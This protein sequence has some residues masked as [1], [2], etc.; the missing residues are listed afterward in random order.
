[1]KPRS[2]LEFQVAYSI[3]IEEMQMRLMR[4]VS[5]LLM[6]F[7]LALGVSIFAELFG[8]AAI[9]AAIS[10]SAFAIKI[11]DP[12]G[13]AGKAETQWSR[14]VALS[15]RMDNLGD[16]DLNTQLHDLMLTDSRVIGSLTHP[17]FIATC[18]QVGIGLGKKQKS[19]TML[20]S[21][22]SFFAGNYPHR[23]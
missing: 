2:E 3:L 17:A 16:A 13:L 4:R 9:A 12:A 19:M 20:E 15:R 18:I 23:K 22:L 8:K 5:N 14:Y 1:M 6:F 21:V 11:W 10:L 7:Q